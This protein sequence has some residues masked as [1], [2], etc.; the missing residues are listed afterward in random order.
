[1]IGGLG[2]QEQGR[3]ESGAIVERA[4]RLA[5]QGQRGTRNTRKHTHIRGVAELTRR[6]CR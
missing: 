4:Y 6:V 2:K 1:M 5:V 3:K